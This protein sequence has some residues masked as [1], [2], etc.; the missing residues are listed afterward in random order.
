MTQLARCSPDKQARVRAFL[1]NG[2]DKHHVAVAMDALATLSHLSLSFFFVGL[3]IYL[4]NIN[5]T[6]FSTV[7]CSIALSTAV[8]VCITLMPVF[9]AWQPIQYT[10]FPNI[11]ANLHQR[12]ILS[13]P[14]SGYIWSSI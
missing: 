3:L 10:T 5:H 6:V 11:L 2:V 9:L 13:L 12:T 4:F 8:Y 1:A 7:V 14:G